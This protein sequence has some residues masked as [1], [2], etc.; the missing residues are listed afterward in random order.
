MASPVPP[1][2]AS[3]SSNC[4]DN[5]VILMP[6]VR[7]SQFL[8]QTLL[9]N[10]VIHLW[11]MATMALIVLPGLPGGPSAD[12]LTRVTF[13]AEHPW[14]WRFGWLPW[15]LCAFIDLVTGIALVS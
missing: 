14:L 4:S 12:D 15:H 13:V 1:I 9:W 3:R 10:F 5:K 2:K 11:A 7:A 8:E 6:S